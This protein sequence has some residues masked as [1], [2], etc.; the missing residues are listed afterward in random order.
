MKSFLPEVVILGNGSWQG[1][2]IPLTPK[3]PE[4]LKR[5][6]IH[7]NPPALKAPPPWWQRGLLWISPDEEPGVSE[8]PRNLPRSL[9]S[10]VR[11]QDGRADRV[12]VCDI[13]LAKP[14]KF[15]QQR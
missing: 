9:W 14:E 12:A 5:V 4:E 8:H 1:A 10:C 6:K 13:P 2:L 11:A 7:R 15:P 3:Q